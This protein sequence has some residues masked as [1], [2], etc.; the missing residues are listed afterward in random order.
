MLPSSQRGPGKEPGC[1][2][3]A[4]TSQVSTPRTGKAQVGRMDDHLVQ[5]RPFHQ[6]KRRGV[7][8]DLLHVDGFVQLLLVPD[9]N[10]NPRSHKGT[11]FLPTSCDGWRRK[12]PI[13]RVSYLLRGHGV[14]QLRGRGL[15][16]E[17]G[18][19]RTSQPLGACTD[20]CCWF[21]CRHPLQNMSNPPC[22]RQVAPPPP[23]A[24]AALSRWTRQQTGDLSFWG[25][26]DGGDR[27]MAAAY[28]DLRLS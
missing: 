17:A 14:R 2:R 26:S 16:R 22:V 11:E 19:R 27:W 21:I 13:K 18:Q 12:R 5:R 20:K 10:L 3:A 4:G 7:N 6:L 24:L 15:L 9:F 8:A 1:L 23:V 25:Q 28:L